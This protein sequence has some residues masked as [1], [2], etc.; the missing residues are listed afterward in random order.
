M[1]LIA[2]QECKRL[3]YC[4]NDIYFPAP[5]ESDLGTGHPAIKL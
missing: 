5:R 1:V 3:E 2:V 4:K